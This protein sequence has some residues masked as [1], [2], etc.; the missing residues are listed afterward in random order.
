VFGILCVNQEILARTSLKLSYDPSKKR[1]HL[2][3]LIA[4]LEHHNIPP[5][6]H[7]MHMVSSQDINN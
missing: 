3:R 6:G 1:A 2:K 7:L 5:A 4:C